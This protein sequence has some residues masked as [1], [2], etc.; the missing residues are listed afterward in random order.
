[1]AWIDLTQ[2]NGFMRRRG[3]R[4][5]WITAYLHV[6]DGS[7]E[8]TERLHSHPWRAS[9]GIVLRGLLLENVNGVVKARRPL[10]VTFYGRDTK[11]RIIGGKAVTL[12][13]G[14]G[15]TQERIKQAAEI[16]CAEGWAHYTEVG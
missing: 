3:W 6:Y 5:K 15:R 7:E 13:I 12:F 4:G 10:S 2:H 11:H 16:K 1:M 9:F 8:P 14:F